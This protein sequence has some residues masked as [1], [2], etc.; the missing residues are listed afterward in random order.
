M[1]AEHT[2][3]MKQNQPNARCTKLQNKMW[4]EDGLCEAVV[5]EAHGK[6]KYFSRYFI[7]CCVFVCVFFPIVDCLHIV[8]LLSRFK[9]LF[10]GS[11]L[12]AKV[13]HAVLAFFPLLFFPIFSPVSFFRFQLI[14]VE[15]C[16]LRK[17]NYF[18]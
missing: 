18:R 12:V 17:I 5:N 4:N 3:Q 9:S 8:L 16:V 10:G 6:Q 15:I 13:F 1:D 2:N 7:L 14:R 11:L